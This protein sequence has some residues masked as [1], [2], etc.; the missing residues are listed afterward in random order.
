MEKKEK[1]VLDNEEVQTPEAEDTKKTVEETVD[2][3]KQEEPDF[4]P[5]AVP[6]TDITE[7][8]LADLKA[9]YEK[10]FVT[11]YMGKRYVWRRLLQTE[12]DKVAQ[13]TDHIEDDDKLV[14]SREKAF[15]QLC[16][17]Y[18]SKEEVEKDIED[19]LIASRVA[20]E[21]LFRSGF[22]PPRTV[23]L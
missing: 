19:S 1:E 5:I 9:E 4:T 8:K 11:D 14:A 18:P 21:I 3:P 17:L 23:E 10:L 16:T 12:F 15:V 22:F 6:G 2:E 20:R 13:D 7:K